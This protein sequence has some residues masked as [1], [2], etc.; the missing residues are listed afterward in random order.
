MPWA[1]ARELLSSAAN[2][3]GTILRSAGEACYNDHVGPARSDKGRQRDQAEKPQV[4]IAQSK[5]VSCPVERS[6]GQK[7]FEGLA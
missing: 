2:V 3:S 1:A 5:R 6:M 7:R 4:R